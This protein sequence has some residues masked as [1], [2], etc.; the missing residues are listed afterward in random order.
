MWRRRN[1][2]DRGVVEDV[3]IRNWGSQGISLLADGEVRTSRVV[4]E[5]ADVGSTGIA[6]TG[7]G[8]VEGCLVRGYIT[9]IDAGSRVWIAENRVEYGFPPSLASVR[10]IRAGSRSTVMNNAVQFSLVDDLAFE[11]GS[12]SRAID[13]FA[14]GGRLRAFGSRTAVEGNYVV[15]AFT[16]S[17]WVTGADNSVTRNR[18][19]NGFFSVDPTDGLGTI[20][21]TPVGAGPWDN[22]DY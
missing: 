9:G 13:N 4:C 18:V 7:N 20:R 11:L 15:D 8:L 22:F 6:M 17:I 1:R 10:G 21:T 19:R 16:L 3:S 12:D 2:G 5:Q 14:I